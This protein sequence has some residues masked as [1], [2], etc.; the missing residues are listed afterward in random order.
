MVLSQWKRAARV[1]LN[2]PFEMGARPPVSDPQRL[3][4]KIVF[5]LSLVGIAS[6]NGRQ[7]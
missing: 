2:L 1:R 3:D 5:T 6:E 4:L 7:S